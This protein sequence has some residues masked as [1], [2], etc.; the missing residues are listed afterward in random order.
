MIRRTGNV[1]DTDALHVGHGV[2]CKGVMGSGIA[3]EVK[4]RFPATY[5]LYREK[6]DETGNPWF[7]LRAG[8]DFYVRENDQTTGKK[9]VI[10]NIASQYHT[11]AN[12]KAE[13]LFAGLTAAA[14]NVRFAG[15]DV[16]AIPFIGCGIGGLSLPILLDC[17]SA[18]EGF[19]PVEFEVWKFS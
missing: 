16:L 14:N 5:S 9:F 19:I 8:Q 1:F 13:W 2:N 11:G 17:V 4:N 3:V 15:D 12:A 18:I 7:R 6:C 10:H